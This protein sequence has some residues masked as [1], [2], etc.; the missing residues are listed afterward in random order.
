[1]NGKQIGFS[2]TQS[3]C[4]PLGG[5]YLEYIGVYFSELDADIL[6]ERRK[7]NADYAN[8]ILKAVM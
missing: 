8:G 6:F 3:Y 5:E 1:M 4:S 7:N 2:E